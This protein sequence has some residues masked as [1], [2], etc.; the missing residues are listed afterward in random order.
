MPIRYQSENELRCATRR[1]RLES[2]ESRRLLAG[3]N[4]AGEAVETSPALVQF[5][6][7]VTN[8]N[9]NPV[10]TA[11]PGEELLLNV[12]VKDMRTFAAD[13]V[14][15]AYVD[16]VMSELVAQNGEIVFG[17]FTNG[18]AGNAVDNGVDELGG[19]SGLGA[20]NAEL[21]LA[22]IP[23]IAL[24]EGEAT[25][26]SN[27]ADE[28][29]QHEVLLS[30]TALAV[31]DSSIE[32]DSVTLNIESPQWHNDSN[33][34]DVNG[35]N[36]VSP[37]DA[38]II[39]NQ[40]N[41]SLSSSLP[42][43]TPFNTMIDV[44]NDGRISAVDALQVI[45]WLNQP[46]TGQGSAATLSTTASS[47]VGMQVDTAEEYVAQ[48][49]GVLQITSED[50]EQLEVNTDYLPNRINVVVDSGVV[51]SARSEWEDELLHPGWEGVDDDFFI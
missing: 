4:D 25:I 31:P 44:N 8:Q 7:E 24:A 48:R 1:P 2:L 30:G 47:I 27:P 12:Y 14:F 49:G 51:T 18:K 37:V 36:V 15:A 11:R 5:D 20:T 45:N 33:P 23:L 34:V 35:D 41:A 26:T 3:L 22:Q 46:P 32:F 19:F 38:L 40:I 16:I 6:L 13:G 21:L 42:A 50:G 43:T 29:P 17:D 28:V 9:G 39:I 10:S